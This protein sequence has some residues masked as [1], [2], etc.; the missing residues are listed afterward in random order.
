MNAYA[1]AAV[2]TGAAAGAW[3]RWQL[4]VWLNA[5]L[6]TVPLGTLASNLIAG[7]LVG[8]SVEVFGQH[9]S[10]SPEFR[11]LIITGFLGGL[12][13]FSTFSAEVVALLQVREYAWAAVASSLHLVG[14][15]LLTIGGIVAARA[16]I[17]EGP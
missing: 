4:G 8:V 7:F 9:T 15:V 17:G 2:G 12:S 6:P 11:L 1:W 10:I 13:T 14:S 3:L 5:L 16:L